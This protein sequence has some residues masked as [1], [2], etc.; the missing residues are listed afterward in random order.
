METEL[1]DVHVLAL[2]RHDLHHVKIVWNESVACVALLFPG[3]ITVLAGNG[4]MPP[5]LFALGFGAQEDVALAH[6]V[7]EAAPVM[8]DVFGFHVDLRFVFDI[9]KSQYI[10]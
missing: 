10:H 7:V 5:D 1:V 6:A 3:G 2:G 4:E 9:P 8:A